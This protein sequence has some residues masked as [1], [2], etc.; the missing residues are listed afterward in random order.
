MSRKK[1]INQLFIYMNGIQVGTLN[2]AT[3]GNLEFVYENSWLNEKNSRPISLSLPLTDISYKG[4]VVS[5]FFENLLPD[6]EV[7]R[8]R[9]QARFGTPSKKSFDLLTHIGRECVGALQFLINPIEMNVRKVEG[10]P[11]DNKSISTLLKEYRIAPLGMSPDSNFRISVAGAQEKTALLWY[12]NRWYLPHD[13]TPTS[14]IIKLPIGY[15]KHS[16]IDLSESVE[17]EW[18]CLKILS[19]HK[20]PV[21]EANIVK[22]EDMTTLVVQRFDRKWSDDGIWLMRLP[23]EDMCQVLGVSPGLKY[24]SDGGP[25]IQSIMQVLQASYDPIK[26][27]DN[28]MKAVFLFWVLGAVDGHAKNFSVSI[29]AGGR[30]KLT[31]LY[32]VISAYP[33]VQ[34][35]QWE[36]QDLKMAMSLKSKNRHYHWDK[37]QSR[38]W[39]AMAKICKFDETQMANIMNEVCDTTEIVIDAVTKILPQNFPSQIAQ[40]I[41]DGMRRVKNKIKHFV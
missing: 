25:G 12:K 31:P 3:T 13:T 41:F 38:H 1:S 17:N 40:S 36:W 20:I 18:L 19:E 39:L 22:F 2:H 33:I 35:K 4:R 6:S 24:E 32:D 26:D 5:N 21:N 11:I 16:G 15:I 23:Q 7:I 14:H 30:Y 37:I 8:E 28:F 9:I 34:K 29:E 10:E 27:R